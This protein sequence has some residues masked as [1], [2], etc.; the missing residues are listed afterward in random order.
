[1]S[2]HTQTTDRDYDIPHE[3][4][5]LNYRLHEEALDSR[6]NRHFLE[7]WIL[8][9]RTA[10]PPNSR[11][12]GL[13]MARINELAL[14]CAA[15]YT[16]S[17]EISAANE[18]LSEENDSSPIRIASL[19]GRGL[20]G[21]I[22][23]DFSDPLNYDSQIQDITEQSEKFCARIPCLLGFIE[24]LGYI[25]EE[26]IMSVQFRIKKIIE[27]ISILTDHGI[28]CLEDL[29]QKLCSI[30]EKKRRQDETLLCLVD[31]S[32]F[33]DLG[34]ELHLFMKSGNRKCKYFVIDR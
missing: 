3:W 16:D 11:C 29:F 7:L 18:L 4:F 27:V 28:E 12:Y 33:D 22:P 31:R 19:N 23:L 5:S 21:P 32:I 20:T 6:I 17:C 1:M 25:S 14:Y 9:L 34:R 24:G 26:Y 2:F 8:R 15:R 10:I 30:E 13:F